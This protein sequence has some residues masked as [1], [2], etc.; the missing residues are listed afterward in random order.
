[1]CPHGLARELYRTDGERCI[2]HECVPPCAWT[3]VTHSCQQCILEHDGTGCAED[4][5]CRGRWLVEDCGR[6][7]EVG[8]PVWGPEEEAV[9]TEEG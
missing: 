9:N 7:H 8:V 3:A 5:H 4:T 6:G 2:I 1:M